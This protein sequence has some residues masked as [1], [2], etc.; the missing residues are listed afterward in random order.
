[1]TNKYKSGALMATFLEFC[2][3]RKPS[4]NAVINITDLNTLELN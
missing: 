3:K 1:M 4:Q 2:C